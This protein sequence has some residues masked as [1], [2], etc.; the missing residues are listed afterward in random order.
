MVFAWAPCVSAALTP[1]PS[2]MNGRGEQSTL[3]QISFEHKKAP[4][5]TE[6]S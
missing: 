5:L 1:G 4:V 6:A 2:P 3:Q